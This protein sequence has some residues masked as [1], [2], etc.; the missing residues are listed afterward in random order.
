MNIVCHIF[1]AVRKQ[2]GKNTWMLNVYYVT[3]SYSLIKK[4]FL[5]CLPSLICMPCKREAID[6]RTAEVTEVHNYN[7]YSTVLK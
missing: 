3:V 2:Y 5:G 6:K 1:L 4:P 7:S